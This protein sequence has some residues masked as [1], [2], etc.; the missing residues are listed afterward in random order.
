MLEGIYYQ[1]VLLAVERWFT[2]CGWPSGPH[3]ISVPYSL[4]RYSRDF[5]YFKPHLD[6]SLRRQIST[7]SDFHYNRFLLSPF[8]VV[9]KTQTN[10]SS[11]QTLRVTQNKDSRWVISVFRV[12]GAFFCHVRPEYLLDT[13]E[14]KHWC[15]MQVRILM[16][17]QSSAEEHGPDYSSVDYESLS[18]RSWTDVLLQIYKVLML[19][20]VPESSLDGMPPFNSLASNIYSSRELQLISWLNLHYQN[21]RGIMWGTGDAPSVRWIVNFDLDFVDGLVL[22][23]LLAAYCPYL[24]SSHFQKIYTRASNLEQIFHN[25]IIVCQVLNALRLNL[26]IQVNTRWHYRGVLLSKNAC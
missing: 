26:D 21:M 18:K 9:A 11:A 20:R 19:H 10:I 4:R 2:L 12:Q 23:S 25:N 13:Q 1:K 15:S 6:T 22:A 5:L 14:F 3:P 24:I 8:R 16:H 7:L 17:T